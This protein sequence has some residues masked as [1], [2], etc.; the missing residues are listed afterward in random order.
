MAQ[1]DADFYNFKEYPWKL[2]DVNRRAFR[3]ER[4][5]VGDV[6]P[7]LSVHTLEG[8]ALSLDDLRSEGNVALVF[9]CWSAPPLV[10]EL[11]ELERLQDDASEHA[12]IVV[13]Y[14]REIH[15]DDIDFGPMAISAH[16]SYE[17][18]VSIARQFRDAYGLKMQ[19]GVDDIEG[20]THS[21]YGLLACPQ[22]VIDRHGMIA[23]MAEFVSA[24]QLR[25]VLFNLYLCDRLAESGTPRMSYSE[26]IWCTGTLLPVRVP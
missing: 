8:D 13:I 19:I 10:E 23:H 25:D 26:T 4:L 21:A 11:R 24:T 18:K 17:N 15:P 7:P 22:F 1:S 3:G 9:G 2:N 20:R 12:K 16:A 14:T 6:A 5:R